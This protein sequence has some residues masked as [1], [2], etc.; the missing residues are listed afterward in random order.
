MTIKLDKVYDDYMKKYE[1]VMEQKEEILTAFIA[2]YGINPEDIIQIEWKKSPYETVWY[3]GHKDEITCLKCKC[4]IG[5][6]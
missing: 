3:V 4:L 1:M 5:E 6:E 2:K